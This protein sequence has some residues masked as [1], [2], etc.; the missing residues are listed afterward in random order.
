MTQPLRVA[1]GFAGGQSPG[2]LASPSHALIG[3]R[4]VRPVS[5]VGLPAPASALRHYGSG[6]PD[7]CH[8]GS[9]GG[10]GFGAGAARFAF[11][12][13]CPGG[14]PS[15]LPLGQLSTRGSTASP[16]AARGA[17]AEP[18]PSHFGGEIWRRPSC[19]SAGWGVRTCVLL[20]APA[21]DAGA[22][23]AAGACERSAN[24]LTPLDPAGVSAD[25]H[26]G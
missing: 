23:A 26:A 21:R 16:C 9:S 15:G 19:T 11:D 17:A 3:H 10:S 13:A 14:G 2:W 18:H 7:R 8:F 5:W 20:Q 1:V 6:R 12:A 24:A 4:S 22:P 25:R